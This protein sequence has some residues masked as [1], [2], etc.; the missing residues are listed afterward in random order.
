[1]KRW[2]LT[3]LAL[4]TTAQLAHAD[5]RWEYDCSSYPCRQI[6]VCDNSEDRPLPIA[7][8]P[9]IPRIPPLGTSFCRQVYVCTGAYCQ[10]QDICQ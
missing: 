4:L 1:M 6:P 5:C 7:P 3:L 10:W 2:T 8:I 9:P